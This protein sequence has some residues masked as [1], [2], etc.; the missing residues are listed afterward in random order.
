MTY[1]VELSEAAEAEAEAA[2]L[3]M[4]RTSPERAGKWYDGLLRAIDSLSEIPYR[5]A[6][7]RESER[8]SEEVRE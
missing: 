1:H 2:F 8:F 5:F 6:V 7:S 4:L 3:W